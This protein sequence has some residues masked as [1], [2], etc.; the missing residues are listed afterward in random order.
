[1]DLDLSGFHHPITRVPRTNPDH[2]SNGSF[3]KNGTI[4][5]CSDGGDCKS[6]RKSFP[7]G[8][9]EPSWTPLRN[10]LRHGRKVIGPILGITVQAL[11]IK[12][13]MSTAYHRQTDRQTERTNQVLEVT[14]VT[15]STMTK[16]IG[17]SCYRWPNTPTMIPK[18]VHPNQPPFANYG[19]HPEREWM[20]KREAQNP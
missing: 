8:S 16:M 5:C 15:S 2:C 9:L 10:C 4:Y 18:Q 20:N 19:F 17:T 12:R 14:F 11:G 1:M 13:R 7:W 3:Y 6:C